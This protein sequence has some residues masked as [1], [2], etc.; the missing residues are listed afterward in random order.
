VFVT[1]LV[2]AGGLSGLVASVSLWVAGARELDR[3]FPSGVGALVIG[4]ALL[5]LGVWLV[6][7]GL[8]RLGVV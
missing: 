3:D 2:L 8:A 5:V 1:A 6:L 7:V 4:C